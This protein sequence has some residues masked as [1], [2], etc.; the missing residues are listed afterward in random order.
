M[1]MTDVYWQRENGLVLENWQG[2]RR[3][4]NGLR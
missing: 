4:K 3:D 2:L 1:K